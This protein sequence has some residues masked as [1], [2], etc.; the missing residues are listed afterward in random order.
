[1]SVE[2]TDGGI[3][4]RFDVVPRDTEAM[5]RYGPEFVIQ[6]SD[7]EEGKQAS[8]RLQEALREAKAIEFGEGLDLT[9]TR[10]P[11]GM[12]DIVGHRL[13]GGKM[14]FGEPERVRPPIPPWIAHL[15]AES[16][17]GTA[18]LDVRLEQ[19]DEMPDGWDDMLVG[20]HGGLTVTVVMR[21]REGEGGEI[22]WNFGYSRNTSPVRE[23]L[24]AV[25]LLRAL[26]GTGEVVITDK[27]PA[28]RPEIRTATPGG[29]IPDEVRALVAFFEDARAIEDWADVEYALLDEIRGEEARN[30]ATV[31]DIV[32]QEGRFITWHDMALTVPQSTLAVLHAGRPVRVEHTA[33]AN[34]LGRLVELGHTQLEVTGY[35]VASAKPAPGKPGYANVRIEPQDEDGEKVFERL[36]KEK[37][38][39]T[40]RPPPPP[41][42]GRKGKGGGKNRKR[43]R[44]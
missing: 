13:T 3:T 26:S 22:R 11:P 14:Q 4:S 39:A 5:E 31:A 1:M 7:G 43:R 10:M 42:R 36:S 44:R 29:G 38:H 8:D 17:F 32:R 34:V 37:M 15:R 20:E 6:P 25:R 40:K 28:K 16:D 24:D 19:G 21:W 33:A 27:G 9:F 2:K 41:R 30:V 35:K 18:E 23:Q 12:K